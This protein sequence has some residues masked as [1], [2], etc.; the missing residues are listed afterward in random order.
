[1]LCR[2][3]SRAAALPWKV[4]VNLDAIERIEESSFVIGVHEPWS[5]L[6]EVDATLVGL[7][8]DPDTHSQSLAR[9]G[10]VRESWTHVIQSLPERYSVNYDALVASSGSEIDKL[11]R[12]TGIAGIHPEPWERRYQGIWDWCRPS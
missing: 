11:Q 5:A 1:M 4:P 10:M 3:I 6:Q 8:R 9:F 7:T 2:M 12:I